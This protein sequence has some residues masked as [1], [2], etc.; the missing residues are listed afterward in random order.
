MLHM[1]REKN[2]NLFT[3]C[4]V[5]YGLDASSLLGMKVKSYITFCLSNVVTQTSDGS[6]SDP[7]NQCGIS[8]F[9]FNL[10][11]KSLVS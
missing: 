3:G 8:P 4:R 2:I 1:Q 10:V 9:E 7:L 11:P 6:F 5:F